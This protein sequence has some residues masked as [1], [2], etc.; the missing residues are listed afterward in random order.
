MQD[1][2]LRERGL[3]LLTILLFM[4]DLP[5]LKLFG[6][7]CDQIDLL[8]KTVHLFSTD[9]GML[10]GIKKCTVLILKIIRR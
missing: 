5:V 9:I 7:S 10:F 3:K 6:N 8:I 1:M 2:N 4:D